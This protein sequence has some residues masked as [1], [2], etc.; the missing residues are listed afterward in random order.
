MFELKIQKYEYVTF[1]KI[2]DCFYFCFMFGFC[3]FEGGA[4]LKRGLN[5]VDSVSGNYRRGCGDK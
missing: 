2:Y 3:N 4:P 1:K 5:G